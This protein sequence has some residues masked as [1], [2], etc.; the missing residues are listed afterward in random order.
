M[1]ERDDLL[2]ICETLGLNPEKSR[3]RV[4]KDTGEKY[5]ESTVKDCKEL[6][7]YYFKFYHKYIEILN[8]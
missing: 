4:N 3:N 8:Q 1:A 2:N 6:K 5:Q 7:D